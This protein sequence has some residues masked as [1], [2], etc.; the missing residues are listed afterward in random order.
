[1]AMPFLDFRV[2]Q[3]LTF[4]LSSCWF[5]A[6]PERRTSL[7]PQAD[8]GW[9]LMAEARILDV[10]CWMLDVFVFPLV[11][12]SSGFTWHPTGYYLSVAGTTR[13][14]T[15]TGTLVNSKS[16]SPLNLLRGCQSRHRDLF[17]RVSSHL[18]K[19]FLAATSRQSGD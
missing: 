16:L 6:V 18:P 9:W 5:V 3:M 14:F 15:N 10:G 13:I 11:L 19:T 7:N 2:A 1:M 4:P 17:S 8:L 12:L